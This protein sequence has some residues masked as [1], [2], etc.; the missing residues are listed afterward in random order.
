MPAEGGAADA[1]FPGS[2]I[3]EHVD[4]DID[5]GEGWARLHVPLATNARVTFLLAGAPVEMAP[6]SVWYLRLSEPHAASNGGTTD[7]IH[8]VIDAVVDDWLMEMLRAA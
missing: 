8:L 7:R 5:A 3:R 6:G 1:P 4:P 2:R